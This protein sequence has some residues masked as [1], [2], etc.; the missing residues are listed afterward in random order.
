M[1]CTEC[2]QQIM[3][4]VTDGPDGDSLRSCGCPVGGDR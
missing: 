4:M 1:T 2:G 3:A